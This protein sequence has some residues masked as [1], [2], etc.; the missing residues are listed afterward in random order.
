MLFAGA[1]LLSGS[2]AANAS[3]FSIYD[4]GAAEQAKGNAVV[5]Q[6]DAPSAVFYN[7][8][9]LA[10]LEGTDLQVGTTAVFPKTAFHSNVTGQ[11][12][13]G[14]A[15]AAFPSY[16]FVSQRLAGA[17][18]M[19]IGI[20]A[21]SGNKVEYPKD[22]EGRFVVT[23]AELR[24][25]HLAP[26][27]AYRVSPQVSVGAGVVLTRADFQQASQIDLSLFS[28]PEGTAD[29][30]GDGYGVGANVGMQARFGATAV[31]A[32]Y[33]SA[34][35]ISFDGNA[36]FQVPAPAASLFPSGGME[37]S[38]KFPQMVIVGVANRAIPRLTLEGDVQ[39]SNWNTLDSQA[40]RFD[41]NTLTVQDTS[42]PLDWQDTWTFRI[43]GQ[44]DVSDTVAFRAGYSFDPSAVPDS[45]L[46]P[47]FPEPDKQ[48]ITVGLGITRGSWTIDLLYGVLIT[49][50]RQANN[51]LTGLPIHNGTYDSS[52]QAV[53]LSVRGRF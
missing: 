22:W 51:S 40:I 49:E 30:E 47:V 11:D 46:S 29:L 8:A 36:R 27:V 42:V 13:D 2:Q 3:G 5:A 9:G 28:L 23:S 20:F 37:T 21:A 7:P 6:V 17:W 1:V 44:Y 18:G 4:F 16:L 19:G 24:Q 12:T 25:V 43:G 38:L 26:S 32:V 31:G 45:T 52:T 35:S 41:T 48:Q 39:W 14:D 10:G 50:S 53:G 33:K 34:S 15:G